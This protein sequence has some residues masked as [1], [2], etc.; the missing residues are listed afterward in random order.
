MENLGYEVRRDCEAGVP[1]Y[2]IIRTEIPQEMLYEARTLYPRVE[3][4]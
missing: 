1:L 3:M 2:E 4:R